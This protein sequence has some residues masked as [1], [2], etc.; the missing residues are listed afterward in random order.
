MSS[1]VSSNPLTSLMVVILFVSMG[2]IA[3]NIGIPSSLVMGGIGAIVTVGI[4]VFASIAVRK[5]E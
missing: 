1:T 5:V 4:I 3:L 2:V